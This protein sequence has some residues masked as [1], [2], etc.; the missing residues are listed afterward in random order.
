M[1]KKIEDIRSQNI[2]LEKKEEKAKASSKAKELDEKIGPRVEKWV[3]EKNFCQSELTIKDVAMQMCTNHNY[4]SAYLNNHL[5][6][7]FQI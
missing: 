2:Y 1:P 5:D 7:T 3:S 6:V 4:L